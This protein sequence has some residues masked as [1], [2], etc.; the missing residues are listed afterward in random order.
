MKSVPCAIDMGARM[1]TLRAFLLLSAVAISL[2][3]PGT[4]LAQ[5]SPEQEVL[6]V[7]IR[8][9]LASDPRSQA[10]SDE[11]I[12]GMVD[13]LAS[14]ATDQGVAAVYL[15]ARAQPDYTA[16]FALTFTDPSPY[17]S[18]TVFLGLLGVI[19]ALGILLYVRSF[20]SRMRIGASA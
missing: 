9:D 19:V 10:L 15:E 5:I 16:D 7:Q 3:V 12:S 18:M 11:E 6:K 17:P 1:S 13:A 20:S 4:S 2:V 14:A 8:S